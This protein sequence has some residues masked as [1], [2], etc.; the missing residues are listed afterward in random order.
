MRK[1]K[2]ERR[3]ELRGISEREKEWREINMICLFNQLTTK[4][5]KILMSKKLN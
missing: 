4:L 3:K 1:R 5:I 2:G